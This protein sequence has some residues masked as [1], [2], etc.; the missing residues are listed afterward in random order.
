MKATVDVKDRREAEA[1]RNGLEDPAVRAF[2][3]ITGALATLT[4]RARDRTMQYVTDKLAEDRETGES[5][6]IKSATING[7]TGVHSQ[8]DAGHQGV[9][10]PTGPAAKHG[11]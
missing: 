7:P 3:I 1:V 2:V 11:G 10:G 9:A 5:A 8:G 4:P 6:T